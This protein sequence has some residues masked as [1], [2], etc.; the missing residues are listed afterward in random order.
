MRIYEVREL[1]RLNL[2]CILGQLG[3]LYLLQ[4]EGSFTL[5]EVV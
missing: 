2:L 1:L 3:K 4:Y 5:M